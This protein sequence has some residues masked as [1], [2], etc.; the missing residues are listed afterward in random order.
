MDATQI[1]ERFL[2][3]IEDSRRLIS[4]FR[5]VE[6]IFKDITRNIKEKKLTEA[7]TKGEILRE[8]LDAHDGL[9]E[10]DQGRS[11]S[12]FWSFLKKKVIG[13]SSQKITFFH[14]LR[15]VTFLF[16]SLLDHLGMVFLIPDIC[17]IPPK[18]NPD[19]ITL[20]LQW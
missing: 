6:D 15:S 8:V 20:N 17:L 10:S 3:L 19:A 13:T 12:A 2:N 1:R 9:E 11:F 18:R 5:L 7:A 4:E 16:I 14:L